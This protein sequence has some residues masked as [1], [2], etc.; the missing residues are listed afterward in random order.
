MALQL[1][2]AWQDLKTRG[3]VVVPAFLSPD[4]LRT[5]QEDYAF[6]GGAEAR[7]KYGLSLINIDMPIIGTF[8][9]RLAGIAD[10]ARRETGIGADQPGFGSYVEV[11]K[12]VSYDWQDWHQDAL[13]YYLG[14][15]NYHYLNVYIPILK[16]VRERSNMNIVPY[17]VLSR[18]V[19]GDLLTRLTGGGAR[20][21]RVQDG[22]TIIL[23]DQYGGHDVLPFDIGA[24][25]FTPLLAAG[26]LL[27][28][29]GDLFHRTQDVSTNRVAVSFRMAGS[30]RQVS[31]RFLG[32]LCVSKL[33]T[34]TGRTGTLS[35][36]YQR[37]FDTFERARRDVMTVGEFNPLHVHL[38]NTGPQDV[39]REELLLTLSSEMVRDPDLFRHNER[40]L[41]VDLEYLMETAP[42]TTAVQE[43]TAQI[44]Q[45]MALMASRPQDVV[46][47]AAGLSFMT[48]SRTLI[49]ALP[50]D[51]PEARRNAA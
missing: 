15:N 13:T 49:E 39:T 28:M 42:Q 1:D 12:G 6:K 37:G 5:L 7:E 8:R 27:L 35:V 21:A 43:A 20:R 23:D 9:D 48:S 46:A 14:Q 17:D 3:F 51:V 41:R 24:D 22:Q 26:D 32:E 11:E 29:R 33:N 34:L 50:P 16:P 25:C 18:H 4:E 10:T 40:H 47:V 30:D 31:R 38:F 45:G 19:G 44:R 2:V 36:L